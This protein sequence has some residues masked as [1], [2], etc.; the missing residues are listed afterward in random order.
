MLSLKS[1]RSLSVWPMKF[2]ARDRCTVYSSFE[3]TEMPLVSS[4][5]CGMTRV[6][7]FTHFLVASLFSSSR[8]SGLLVMCMF[9]LWMFLEKRPPTCVQFW[10]PS[11]FFNGAMSEWCTKELEWA[12]SPFYSLRK[13]SCDLLNRLEFCALRLWLCPPFK[14]SCSSFL[15][16]I[17]FYRTLLVSM[18]CFSSPD[19]FLTTLFAISVKLALFWPAGE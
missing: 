16:E 12:A 5:W 6:A 13:S 19:T 18:I 1:Y 10:A 9:V 2:G 3:L 17:R 7:F 14:I 15:D 11:D 8:D 4:L